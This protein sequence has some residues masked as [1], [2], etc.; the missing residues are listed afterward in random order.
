MLKHSINPTKT[1]SCSPITFTHLNLTPGNHSVLFFQESQL[2]KV[3]GFGERESP[4][5]PRVLPDIAGS[6]DTT[7]KSLETA[8]VRALA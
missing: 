2:R 4:P 1:P 5:P 7:V 6:E 8:S 3:V